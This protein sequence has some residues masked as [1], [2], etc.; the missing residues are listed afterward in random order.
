MIHLRHAATMATMLSLYPYVFESEMGSDSFWTLGPTRRPKVL[1]NGRCGG[2][3]LVRKLRKKWQM[4]CG[5]ALTHLPFSCLSDAE[6]V[7]RIMDEPK[8]RIAKI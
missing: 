8:K 5:D 3:S 7:H 4:R 1:S 2:G 6:E